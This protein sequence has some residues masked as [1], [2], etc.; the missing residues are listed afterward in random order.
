MNSRSPKHYFNLPK[1]I[2]PPVT[3][4][5]GSTWRI[6]PLQAI[7]CDA[8]QWAWQA[9]RSGTAYAAASLDLESL[10]WSYRCDVCGRQWQAHEMAD[11]CVCG[12]RDITMTGSDELLLLSL[13][14]QGSDETDGSPLGC[15]RGQQN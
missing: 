7:D 12:A 11:A 4:W 1:Y 13:D 5:T 8:L 14:V 3:V 6:G 15:A 9:A 2:D 10:P